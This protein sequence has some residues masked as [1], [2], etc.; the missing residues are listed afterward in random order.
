MLKR[1]HKRNSALISYPTYMTAL[2]VLVFV[3]TSF[4][5]NIFVMPMNEIGDSL[6]G[7]AGV[8]AFLWIIV[9]VLLQNRDLKLQYE[10]IKDMKQASESQARSLKSAEIFKALEYIEFKFER[11]NPR[12]EECRDRVNNEIKEFIETYETGRNPRAHFDPEKD[13]CEIWGYFRKSDVKNEFLY[14]FESVRD[15]FDYVAYLKLETIVRNMKYVLDALDGLTKNAD[16]EIKADLSST[17]ETWEQLLQVHWY[18]E[19]RVYLLHIETVVKKAI[20][21]YEIGNDIVRAVIKWSLEREEE[22]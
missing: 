9:T 15:N 20:V 3:A 11:I 18:R 17:I 13:I 19:W 12:I 14:P 22:C 10:E 7:F 5:K 4:A 8:L 1:F 6:A 16:S 2:I 21:E